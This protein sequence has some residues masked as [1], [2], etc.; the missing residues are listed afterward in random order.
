MIDASFSSTGR[1]ATVS[2]AYQYDTGQRLRMHGLPSPSE[3]A[4]RDSLLG[5]DGITVQAQF[6]FTGDSQTEMRLA[7]WEQE[8]EDE[9]GVWVAEIPDV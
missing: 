7:A 3:L 2:G 9:P 8:T 5:G 4:E 1:D 6:S